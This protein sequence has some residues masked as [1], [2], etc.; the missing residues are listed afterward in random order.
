MNPNDPEAE[1]MR[2][3]DGRTPLAYKAEQEA[4][5][6]LLSSQEDAVIIQRS[7][8]RSWPRRDE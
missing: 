8:C 2:L 7:H 5:I 4:E 6:A 3:K 1:I